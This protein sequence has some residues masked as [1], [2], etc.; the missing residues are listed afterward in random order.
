MNAA[1][2]QLEIVILCN[3]SDVFLTRICVA[4]IRYYYPGV[5]IHIVKDEVNGRFSTSSLEKA[6]KVEVLDLGLKNYGWCTGK[7][8]VL[9]SGK[10]AGRKILLLDSDIVF[11]GKVLDTLLPHLHSADFIVSPEYVSDPESDWFPKI[12]YDTSW[13]RQHFS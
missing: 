2:S 9:L 1:E 12:Y 4:S 13:A 6:F 7:I 11:I 5:A 8:S 10:L 3:R